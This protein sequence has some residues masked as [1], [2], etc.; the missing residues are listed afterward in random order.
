MDGY[1]D[2]AE[3]TAAALQDGWYHTG[4]LGELDAE[5]YVSVVG[6]LKEIIRTGGE[7]VAPAEVEAAL[8]DHPDVAEVAVVGIPDMRWGEVICAVVVPKPGCTPSLAALQAHCENRLAS[9]KK[10]RRLE[11]VS[12]LPRTA[13]TGQVQRRLLV[14]RIVS[15]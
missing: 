2:D 9:F 3:A 6:R 8:A 15:G 12:E 13:A 7:G 14:E 11:C 4:D 1:F 5:G 10:P